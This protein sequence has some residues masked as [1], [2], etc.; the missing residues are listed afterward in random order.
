[1]EE[2][3]GGGEG[4]VLGR[5]RYRRERAKCFGKY[6][7]TEKRGKGMR[8]RKSVREKRTDIEILRLVCV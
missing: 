3:E 7:G 8:G 1:M 5:H 4:S 2:R 6:E